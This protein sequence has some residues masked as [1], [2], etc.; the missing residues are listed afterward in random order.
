MS[1]HDCTVF[2]SKMGTI[3]YA[4]QWAHNILCNKYLVLSTSYCP[5]QGRNLYTILSPGDSLQQHMSHWP[6]WP[7]IY[8]QHHST[9]FCKGRSH[10]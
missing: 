4:T 9:K 1:L 3:I 6:R 5:V 2:L 10:Q 8:A 7:K